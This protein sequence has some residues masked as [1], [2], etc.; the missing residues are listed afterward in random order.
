M[1]ILTINE[2]ASGYTHKFA[3]DYTDLNDTSFLAVSTL[4]H[5]IGTLEPGD[6]IDHLALYQITA[7]GGGQTDLVI[8]VG[9]TVGAPV[10]CINQLDLDTNTAQVVFDQGT[11]LAHAT[12]DSVINATAAAIPLYMKMAG[13]VASVTAGS[14]VIAWHQMKCPLV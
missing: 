4:V 1:A 5:T 11:V 12:V 13:T 10:E 2:S 9:T 6:A 3:F 8:D 7:D 14:W